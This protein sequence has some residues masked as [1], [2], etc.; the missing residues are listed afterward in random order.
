MKSL[1]YG[2]LGTAILMATGAV[3]AANLQGVVESDAVQSVNTTQFAN[4]V[5]V[6]CNQYQDNISLRVNGSNVDVLLGSDHQYSLRAPLSSDGHFQAT[7]E[8][9]GQGLVNGGL[10]LSNQPALTVSGQIDQRS[11]EAYGTVKMAPA[12]AKTVACVGDFKANTRGDLTAQAGH[13]FEVSYVIE[14]RDGKH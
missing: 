6:N 14:D 13:P 4:T 8:V 7:K 2:V 3:N 10:F 9:D 12:N 11:G 1:K 5:Q